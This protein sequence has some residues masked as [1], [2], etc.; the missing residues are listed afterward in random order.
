MLLHFIR[1]AESLANIGRSSEID[2]DLS[3]KGRTQVVAVAAEM[4]RLGVDHVLT[5][6]YR[7]A[8]MTGAAIANASGV[9]FEVHLR[10]HEHQ[11]R[12]WPPAW[13]LLGRAD[14]VRAFPGLT[15]PEDMV[16][17]PDW[18]PAPESDTSLLERMGA[19][20]D[21]IVAR[22]APSNRIALISHGAPVGRALQ[23]FLGAPEVHRA[24]VDIGNASITTLEVIGAKR[25]VRVV[26]RMDHLRDVIAGVPTVM[27][28][29]GPARL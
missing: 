22:F 1:H 18:H 29:F 23:A 14:L 6:P 11:I 26:N 12:P 28:G 2:C 17:G 27:N 15:V 3:D 21:G 7:R 5:S 13:P 19:V 24:E 10:L 4:R 16:E 8:L 25:Y 9:P 20:I